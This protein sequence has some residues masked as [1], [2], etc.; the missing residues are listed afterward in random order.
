[1]SGQRWGPTLQEAVSRGA[2]QVARVLDDQPGRQRQDDERGDPAR[3]VPQQGSDGQ[4]REA[5]MALVHPDAEDV[6]ARP[7]LVT[8]DAKWRFA[9]RTHARPG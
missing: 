1:M 8:F 7:E 2:E 4:Q 3:H 6:A 5:E 9:G